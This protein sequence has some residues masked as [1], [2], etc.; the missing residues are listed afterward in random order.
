[1]LGGLVG[2]LLLTIGGWGWAGGLF[3]ALSAGIILYLCFD[4]LLPAAYARSSSHTVVYGVLVGVITMLIVSV[5][6]I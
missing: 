6:H 1:L 2:V 4:E 3:T 5:V